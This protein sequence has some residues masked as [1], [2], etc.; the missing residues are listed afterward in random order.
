MILLT[1]RES[2]EDVIAGL[3]SGADDYL[4]KPFIADELKARLA[5]V[6][7]SC[8]WKIV[9]SRLASRCVS[10]PHTIT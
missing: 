10:K 8:T 2:K 1:S 3:E 6:E 4:I 5:S 9:S 7:R